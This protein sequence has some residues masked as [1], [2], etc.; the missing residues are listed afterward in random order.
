MKQEKNTGFWRA[1]FLFVLIGMGTLLSSCDLERS[2]NGE[3]DGYWHLV[4]VDTLETGGHLDLSQQKIFWAV[5]AKLIHLSGSSEEFYL[6]FRQTDD[7][8]VV[9]QPYLDNGHQDNGTDGGDIPVSD[10]SVLAPYGI[11]HLEEPFQKE[12]LTGSR[13]I[14]KSTAL[15]LDF[16]KF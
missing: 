4:G 5:Q 9:N 3:L 11:L 2:D 13:M 12:K 8:V 15:R 10:A 6:R 7:S 1:V 14:L 16:R